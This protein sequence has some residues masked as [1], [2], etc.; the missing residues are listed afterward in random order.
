MGG[1]GFAYPQNLPVYAYVG[2][3]M[4]V[5]NPR[6]GMAQPV[7]DRGRVDTRFPTAGVTPMT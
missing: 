4:R 7:S 3:G 5:G 2:R 1:D 6:A